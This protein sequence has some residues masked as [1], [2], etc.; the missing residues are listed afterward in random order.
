MFGWLKGWITEGARVPG[1]HA[2]AAYAALARGG[3]TEWS[4]PAQLALLVRQLAALRSGCQYCI[5]R[6][7]HQAMQAGLGP[8]LLDALASYATSPR[9]TEP[10]RAAL[11]LAQAVTCFQEARGGVPVQVLAEARRYFTES[12]VAAIVALTAEEHFFD[13]R[14]VALVR[15]ACP[16]RT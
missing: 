4:L 15:D 11:A 6:G 1:P 7:R 10:E 12:E 2:L 13:V 14:R 5:H 9:F 8:G 16:K 3:L